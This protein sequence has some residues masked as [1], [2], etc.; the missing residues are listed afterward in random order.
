MVGENNTSPT[1]SA[2][3]ILNPNLKRDPHSLATA[4][5]ELSADHAA[6]IGG[7]EVAS[8]TIARHFPA[9]RVFKS[10]TRLTRASTEPT[11]QR[12]T[13]F[14]EDLVARVHNQRAAATSERFG[15]G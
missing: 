5:H 6:R 2:Q 13:G 3:R 11:F 10:T 12:A 1:R 7:A 15:L 8:V 9:S 14:K 4:D